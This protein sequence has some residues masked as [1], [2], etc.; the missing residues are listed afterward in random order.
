MRIKI[1]SLRYRS[2][3]GIQAA[4]RD[5]PG[6]GIAYLTDQLTQSLPGGGRIYLA[7]YPRTAWRELHRPG[8]WEEMAA[9]A[10][11]GAD[12]LYKFPSRGRR[13]IFVYEPD[14]E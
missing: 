6:T 10:A 12:I 5:M 9:C 3:A 4:L 2:A 1:L 13:R 14:Q 8:D 11:Q 7:P